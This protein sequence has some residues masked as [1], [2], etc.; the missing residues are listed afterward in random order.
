MDAIRIPKSTPLRH[1]TAPALATSHRVLE[2]PRRPLVMGIVNVTPDSFSDGG[3]YFDVNAAVD[4]ALATGGRRRRYPRHRRR[5]HAALCGRRRCRRR[6]AARAARD[7]ATRRPSYD[8]HFDRH[9]QS[10]R[11]PSGDRRRRRNHQRRHRPHRR[12]RDDRRRR[13]NWRRRVCDAHAGHA[14]D[15]AG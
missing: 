8:S 3:Q 13:R 5:K 6:T 14:A 12:P 7:R 4:H 2:F 15:D 11:R 1:R 9:Q 10:D